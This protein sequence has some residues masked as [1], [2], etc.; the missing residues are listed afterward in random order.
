MSC[1][2]LSS[3]VSGLRL[4]MDYRP[5][6]WTW[7]VWRMSG[8]SQRGLSL[9]EYVGYDGDEAQNVLVA[10]VYFLMW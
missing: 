10:S 2:F 8:S 1:V 4:S 5:S 3:G 6:E 7:K 9:C